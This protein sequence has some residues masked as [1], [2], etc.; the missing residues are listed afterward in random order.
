MSYIN[1]PTNRKSKAYVTPG[2]AYVK[3]Y[4]LF[5]LNTEDVYVTGISVINAYW[6]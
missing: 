4:T 5:F 6:K 2:N 1:K 3:Y